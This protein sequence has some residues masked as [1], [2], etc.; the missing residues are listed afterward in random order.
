MTL[1]L[2]HLTALLL[3]YGCVGALLLATELLRRAGKMTPDTA[4]KIVH[5]GVGLWVVPTILVFADWRVAIVPPLTFMVANYV[6]HRFRLSPLDSDPANL[7]TV[8]FPFSFAVLLA[9]FF[10][11]GEPGNQAFLAVAGLLTMAL[12]DA[13]AAVFGKRYGTRRYTI[14]GHSRTM[15]G[16][17]AM[18]L[19]TGVLIA[20]VLGA[21]EDYS[22]HPAVAFGLVTGTA[23][24]G[25]EA[26]CPFGSDNLFVPLG[27][28]AILWAL[29]EVSGAALGVI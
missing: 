5:V 15:E 28:A 16:S 25:I 21:M 18:F 27:T 29:V 9:V 6:I 20:A 4:R 26:V 2:P 12:G 23:A 7:G 22:W 19:V 8:F 13:A 11:P 3:S 14:L 17:M 10:R 1:P 24:A